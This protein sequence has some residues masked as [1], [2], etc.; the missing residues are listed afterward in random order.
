MSNKEEGVIV[1]YVS[2]ALTYLFGPNWRTSLWGM[3]ALLPQLAK[4]VQDLLAAEKIPERWLNIVTLAFAVLFV[5]NAKDR[6]VTGGS[7]KAIM[8]KE[9]KD[10]Q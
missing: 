2:R 3:L 9:S 1:Y 10:D 8:V 5:I 7:V 6:Q 4:P